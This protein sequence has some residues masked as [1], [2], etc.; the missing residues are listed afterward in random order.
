[1]SDYV[2]AK[3]IRLPFPNNLIEKL[4][5]DDCWECEDYLEETLG[6]LWKGY[7]KRSGFEI[8][9]TSKSY[10]LDYILESQY[11]DCE[12]D[13]GYAFYLDEN[14][15]KKYKPLFDKVG[16][17]YDIKDLRKVVYCYY[18]GCECPDYYDPKEITFE[19]L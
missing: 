19:S 11:G 4:R 18:N 12:G 8:E 13:Y 3:V 1:M 15:I 7:D 10:Y 5:V 9:C 16:V 14:D 6:D 17:D 2:R